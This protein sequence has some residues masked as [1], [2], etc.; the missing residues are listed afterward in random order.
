MLSKLSCSVCQVTIKPND[1]VLCECGKPYHKTCAVQARNLPDGTYDA[2]CGVLRSTRN[3]SSRSADDEVVSS[4]DEFETPANTSIQAPTKAPAKAEL[5]NDSLLAIREIIADVLREAGII[6]RLDS[7][8]ASFSD[9]KSSTLAL[10]KNVAVNKHEV[11]DIDTFLEL[12]SDIT[13]TREIIPSISVG[14]VMKLRKQLKQ[15]ITEE[16]TKLLALN[17][18]ELAEIPDFS[19]VDVGLNSSI[20]RSTPDIEEQPAPEVV[21]EEIVIEDE[22]LKNADLSKLAS[23]IVFLFPK[24]EITTYYTDPLRKKNS[25]TA[26]SGMSKGKLAD[27]WRNRSTFIRQALS[28]VSDFVPQPHDSGISIGA[29]ESKEWLVHNV[30]PLALV[31]QH[32]NNCRSIR[33][34]DYSNKLYKS[35]QD[36]TKKWP[37]LNTSQGFILIE[38]DFAHKF[39]GLQN[40]LL[41]SFDTFYDK[42]YLQFKEKLKDNDK[43]LEHK[44]LSNDLSRNSGDTIKFWILASLVAPRSNRV[45]L[46][47][48]AGKKFWKPSITECQEGLVLHVKLPGDIDHEINERQKK[49]QDMK[50]EL[51]SFILVVGPD[52]ETID[53]VYVCFDSTKYEYHIIVDQSFG[54]LMIID[55]IN[56]EYKRL[57]YLEKENFLIAPESFTIGEIADDKNIN[58]DMVSTIKKCKAYVVPMRKVLKR[59]LEL[60]NVFKIATNY[61]REEKEGTDGEKIYSSIISGLLWKK[62]EEKYKD[63]IVMP[64]LIYYDDFET[65]DALSPSAGIHKIGGL[66]YSLAALPRK[67]ATSLENIFLAQFIHSNDRSHFGNKKSFYKIIEELKYLSTNGI[68]ITVDGQSH[69]IYFATMTILGDNL[70]INTLLGFSGFSAEFFCRLCQISST[71]S[72]VQCEELPQLMRTKENYQ[73][74]IENLSHGVKEACCFNDIPDFDNIENPSCDIMHDFE[75]SLC[76]YVM[77]A[78]INECIMKKYFTLQRLNERIKYFNYDNEIDKGNKPP[79]VNPVH[80]K[81]N[82]I[83]MTAAQMGAFVCY[84]G[85]IIGDLV[86]YDEQIWE[87][88]T[89]LFDIC[90]IIY[91]ERVS[92]SQL[93]YLKQLIKTHNKLTL[94]FLKSLKPKNHLISHI[95][96]IYRQLG[97]VRQL[98]SIRFEAF[99]LLSKNYARVVKSRVNICYTLALKLQLQFANKIE[100]NGLS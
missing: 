31:L 17:Q 82:S 74:D 91:N 13:T 95:V 57:K 2:C 33:E 81:K 72:S 11:V 42:V 25:K 7:I 37:I 94:E 45:I 10:K 96:H 16:D 70:G 24:E 75:D 9:L 68:S 86:P 97:T 71:L 35:I 26:K 61:I 76:R 73:T 21:V 88:Y 8:E 64:L 22:N 69:Q 52:I 47:E 79:P 85:M 4:E 56:T 92:E 30:D 36:I 28:L 43:I 67:Y 59:F 50:L 84:F 1:L 20:I 98:S 90:S 38:Q 49:F 39:P 3:T 41:N 12:L 32:W 58:N 89:T 23:L 44:L 93:V 87:L 100:H 80:L 48:T 27:K 62:I 83:T 54:K 34:G 18:S 55:N 29:D 14:S 51:Q 99:H 19:F 65:G 5:T 40:K 78:V 66:Y 63:K 15:H 60:P 6:K 46:S 53:K 77:A